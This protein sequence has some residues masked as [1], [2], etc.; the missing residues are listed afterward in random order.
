MVSEP[1]I[2]HGSREAGTPP[3]Q[4][5]GATARARLAVAGLLL[6]AY[7]IPLFYPPT[8]VALGT[9][10]P[11]D[12]W[13]LA[14]IFPGVP[15]FW[16]AARLAALAVAAVLLS[17]TDVPALRRTLDGESA[18]PSHA[19]VGTRRLVALA[20]A[21]L[22]A[23][24]A[25]WAFHLSPVGQTAY[26]LTLFVPAALLGCPERLT[27]RW[28][29]R[30]AWS[31][32]LVAAVIV[33]WMVARLT[34]DL[35]SPRV[36]DV[37]DGWRGWLD[38]V[39]FVQQ[40]KNLLTDLFDPRLP[41][42][43][44]VLLSLHGMPLFQ[45][46]I[47]PLSF[48]WVQIFQI[49]AIA[50]CAAGIGALTRM[51][52]GRGV[53]AI[54]V[55]VFLFAPYTRFVT[56]FPG[57][58]L[59]GPIYATAVA[60]CAVTCVRRRSEAPLAALGACAGIAIQFPGV[61][62]VL[63]FLIAW[64]AWHLRDSWRGL[65]LGGAAALASFAA[66]VVPAL[67]HVLVPTEMVAHFRWD[68]LISIIDGGLLGQLPLGTTPPAWEGV[69]PRPFDIVVAALLA[70]FAHPRLAIR[71]WGDA[72]FDP[73]G[74][75]LIAVGLAACVRSAL[76]S[77]AARV[78]LLFFAAA[79]CPAFVSPVDVVD[80]VHAVVLPV[81]AALLAAL[82]FLV[83]R[84][85][86]GWKAADAR[87]LAAVAIAVCLGG[88]LLFDVVNPRILS[89]SSFGIMFRVLTSGAAQRVV[90]LTYGP[91]FVRK[92]KTL[93]TGPIT[94]FG[95]PRPVGYLAYE[96]GDLPVSDLAAEGKDLFFWSHGFD[97]DLEMTDA[98]C[99]QWPDATLYEIW[100]DAGLGRVH[101]ARVGGDAWKPEG[102]DGKWRSWSCASRN[103]RPD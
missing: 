94:A 90:V 74:S 62:P 53:A 102:A 66:A 6:F 92:T 99:R 32:V 17:G 64:T 82:G 37:I 2:P 49:V 93:F 79:L 7:A 65:W 35:E 15:V 31:A 52:L 50:A 70:P 3:T 56:L 36:A 4:A 89:A 77:P 73:V 75:A 47:L 41:G 24:S 5:S 8:P 30:L 16:I 76:R 27:P 78:L 98:I 22:Q 95:G 51:L 87:A 100:D 21:L 44:G 38:V 1:Q 55:A 103:G 26:L 54:A 42:M 57:P 29:P 20:G 10:T 69:S 71:L 48:R 85:Q 96:G 23:C 86:L 63:A 13:L 81:P 67:A 101:G 68:G 97:Q 58:F 33:A 61:M 45:S 91:S 18:A 19:R 46:D 39:T 28:R 14:R 43:G 9:L 72:L 84:Q 59:A 11:P 12:A 83:V 80:I 34:T 40:K 88:T 25:P 60:L